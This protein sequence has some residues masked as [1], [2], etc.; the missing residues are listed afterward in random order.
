MA[1]SAVVMFPIR[2]PG[3][4]R[5]WLT[6]PVPGIQ[7]IRI[8]PTQG[9]GEVLHSEEGNTCKKADHEFEELFSQGAC[10]SP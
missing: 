3:R 5:A 9:P 10:K 1:D 8:S 7:A 4:I 6:L 2:K